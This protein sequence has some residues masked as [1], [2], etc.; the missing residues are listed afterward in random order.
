MQASRF[1]KRVSRLIGVLCVA[2][3]VGGSLQ[4][5]PLTGPGD[6]S[7]QIVGSPE[8]RASNLYCVEFIEIDDQNIAGG[9]EVIWLEPGRYTLTVRMIIRNPPGLR[10]RQTN[11]RDNSGY[12]K[13]ELVVE[14]GKRYHVLAKYDREREGAP[15]RTVLYRVEDMDNGR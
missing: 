1:S 9:R 5:S 12:N 3:M 2:L 6:H 13:I 4:A 15:Y 8:Y 14:A 10:S 7:A 11:R